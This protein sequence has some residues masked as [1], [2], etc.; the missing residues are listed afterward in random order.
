MKSHLQ[1]TTL[2]P[3]ALQKDFPISLII[4]AV[5]ENGEEKLFTGRNIT[6]KSLMATGAL[7]SHFHAVR[8][9]QRDYWDGAL[10]GGSNPPI[11]PLLDG[12][13]DFRLF[14]MTN[15]PQQP[16][17]ARKQ[18]DLNTKD[19]LNTNGLILHQAYDEIALLLES[20]EAGT[21]KTPIHVIHPD[22][23]EPWSAK[24][25]QL[26]DESIIFKRFKMG[27]KAA[28]VFLKAHGSTVHEKSS[29]TFE[30]LKT[31]ATRNHDRLV[32]A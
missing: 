3:N 7:P 11:Q 12:Q 4:N 26:V 27:I 14:I 24:D 21:D 2:N 25:K 5:D 22:I 18:S 13:A 16:I 30:D 29:I 28:E 9:G 6:T 1:N 20:H 19:V 17:K 8:I 31:K 23:A 15:P 32:A 10:L